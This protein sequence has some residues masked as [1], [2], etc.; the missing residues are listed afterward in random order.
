V[1]AT[2][3]AAAEVAWMIAAVQVSGGGCGGGMGLLFLHSAAARSH[4]F[5]Q[6]SP[7]VYQERYLNA[8]K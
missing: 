1:R 2:F 8:I 6:L 5:V 7:V 3:A 4:P